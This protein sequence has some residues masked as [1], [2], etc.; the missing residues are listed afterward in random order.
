MRWEIEGSKNSDDAVRC[1]SE[2][3]TAVAGFLRFSAGSLAIGLNAQVD[4]SRYRVGFLICLPP[5]LAG[6]HDDG[7]PKL[8]SSSLRNLGKSPCNLDPFCKCVIGPVRIT[9]RSSGESFFHLKRNCMF[10]TK[11]L[12]SGRWIC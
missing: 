10:R 6:L 2:L 12:F 9:F 8:Y 5:R 1:M 11:N 3:G 4:F 7:L